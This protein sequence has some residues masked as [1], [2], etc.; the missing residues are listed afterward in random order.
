[1][2]LIERVSDQENRTRSDSSNRDPAFFVVEA[3]VPLGD[4]VG[5][6]ENEQRSVKAHVMLAQILRVL[7]LIPF[8]EHRQSPRSQSTPGTVLVSIHLYIH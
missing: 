6:V 5:I 7:V 4:R 3:D 8:E 2:A 1:M